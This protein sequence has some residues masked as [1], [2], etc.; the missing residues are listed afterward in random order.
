MKDPNPTDN[1]KGFAP[2]SVDAGDFHEAAAVC[3]TDLFEVLNSRTH[4]KIEGIQNNVSN[5]RDEYFK[6]ERSI[7]DSSKTSDVVFLG[8]QERMST[9]CTAASEI[10]NYSLFCHQFFMFP[11]SNYAPSTAHIT[12]GRR[13]SLGACRSGSTSSSSRSGSSNA[14]QHHHGSWWLIWFGC[15]SV[16]IGC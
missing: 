12:T 14:R 5:E 4:E 9:V 6:V 8:E 1:T 2:K 15:R 3:R 16:V 7:E 13:L 10:T 11:Y